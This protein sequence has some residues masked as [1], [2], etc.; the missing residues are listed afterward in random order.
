MC[1][2]QDI[3]NCATFVQSNQWS[4]KSIATEDALGFLLA[5]LSSFKKVTTVVS[6]GVFIVLSNISNRTFGENS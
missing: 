5:A 4:C 1:I 3:E 6:R 2:N